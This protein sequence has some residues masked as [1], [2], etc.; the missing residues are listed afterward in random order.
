MNGKVELVSD[1]YP[2][3]LRADD[4]RGQAV[5]VTIAKVDLEV[6]HTRDGQEKP[7]LVLSFEK[8]RRRLIL[9]RTQARELCRILQSERLADWPGKSVTL[10]PG[11]A[12]NG[13]QTIVVKEAAN[14]HV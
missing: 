5:K 9:N 3:W 13:R 12:P 1:I 10:A 7:A 8:A 4:L 2:L 11:Q 14:A 6:F